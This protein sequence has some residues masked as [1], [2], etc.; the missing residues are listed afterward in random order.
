VYT[1]QVHWAGNVHFHYL[2]NKPYPY[3]LGTTACYRA[4]E[5]SYVDCWEKQGMGKCPPSAAL[6]S[7]LKRPHPCPSVCL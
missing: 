6:V 2:S 7:A 4:H 3:E 1:V 5:S